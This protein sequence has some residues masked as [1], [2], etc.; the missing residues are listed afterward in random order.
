M[1]EVNSKQTSFPSGNSACLTLFPKHS[2]VSYD[3]SADYSMRNHILY[4]GKKVTA[5]VSGPGYSFLFHTRKEPITSFIKREGPVSA[6]APGRCVLA[7]H[8][9]LLSLFSDSN[10]VTKPQCPCS[11]KA[12]SN[13]LLAGLFEKLVCV[14]CLYFPI[15]LK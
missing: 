11:E 2:P 10:Q 5:R 9:V 8:F 6:V 1:N 14:M 12:N 15:V 7:D 13:I 4:S 3:Y